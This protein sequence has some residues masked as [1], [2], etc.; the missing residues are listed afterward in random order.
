MFL[1]NFIEFNNIPKPSNRRKFIIEFT[2]PK[3]KK[4][5]K[6]NYLLLDQFGEKRFLCSKCLRE[7]S[8]LEKYGVTNIAKSEKYKNKIL[9]TKKEKYGDN[10]GK[11]WYNKSSKTILEK[12]NVSNI[13]ELSDHYDKC[14][15]TMI[16]KYGSLENA[17]KENISKGNNS[18]ILKYG[19][20]EN[21][22]KIISEK[23]KKAI[24]EKYNVDN[25]SQTKIWKDKHLIKVMNNLM[26]TN[27]N[28]KFFY[29]KDDN[30]YLHCIECNKDFL[31][32]TGHIIYRCPNCFPNIINNP[33]SSYE[34]LEVLNYIKSVYNG[35]IEHRKK[36]LFTNSKQEIDI[37]LPELK[38]GI[39]FDGIYWHCSDNPNNLRDY[40]KLIDANN[41]GIK[42]IRIWEN[43]WN[44]KQDIV[45]SIINNIL[46]IPCKNIIQA[47]NCE[48]RNISNSACKLFCNKNSLQGEI[49]SSV[50]LG[51]FYKEDLVQIISLNKLHIHNK[52]EWKLVRNCCKLNTTVVNGENKLLKYF[53]ETYKPKSIIT[54]CN[55]RYF[56]GNNYK[57]LGFKEQKTIKPIFWI[58]D[59]HK[60]IESKLK[61]T[62]LSMK[63]KKDFIYNENLS[64]VENC[65]NN[66]YKFLVDCGQLVF[67][68]NINIS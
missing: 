33:S 57:L 12:Y 53:E 38:V 40:N 24:K 23:S 20:I 2:C 45:K 59:K 28:L 11:N 9:N 7:Q 17:Y 61:Y 60:N 15:R 5:A 16:S 54:Y 8:S 31:E 67:I 36:K 63:N 26:K 43:E 50:N 32:K 25:F 62:K 37:Y 19:S 14:K 35:Q 1:N 13:G 48:I 6:S 3:C 47:N 56:S 55:R 27:D 46:N 65:L 18:K 49:N 29:K 66:G 4:L 52:Y 39:E 68:K 21:Y 10:W 58:V 30:Y 44:E 22:N 64:Q 42:L 34:E 51:L 41:R